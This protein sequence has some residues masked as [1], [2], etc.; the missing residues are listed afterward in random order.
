MKPM[1]KH[2]PDARIMS[3]YAA[4][5]L[6]LA[7]SVCVSIHLSYCQHCQRNY[8]R[9]QQLGAAMFEKLS[10][11]QV[12][13]SLLESV[14]GRLDEEP[15]LSY[16]R[17]KAED[18]YPSLVERLMGGN[19]D[20]LDWNRVT[21][22]LRI[23]RLRTGDP[24]NELSLYHIKAGGSI[25][26]HTHR[27]PEMTLVMEGAFSDEEGVYHTGDF[28]YRDQEHEHTPTA[29]R[30]GDCICI[31]VVDAPVQFTSWKHRPLNPF[32]SVNPQ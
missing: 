11:V 13:D 20:E 1:I 9:L 30:G 21:S 12:D 18:S 10:P 6:P 24:A 25:P 28:I 27:G 8:Q 14:M 5:S 17:P 23:S 7:Q 15:P 3:E 2:H 22:S 29:T 4:G 16:A 19:Y 26:K 32:L 31:G